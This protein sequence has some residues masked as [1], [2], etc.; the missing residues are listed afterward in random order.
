MHELKTVE[1]GIVAESMDTDEN[2]CT[3]SICMTEL[4]KSVLTLAEVVQTF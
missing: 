3:K 4:G 1:A 2:D